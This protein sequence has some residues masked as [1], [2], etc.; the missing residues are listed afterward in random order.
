MCDDPGCV[1]EILSFCRRAVINVKEEENATPGEIVDD[2]SPSGDGII[3]NKI[4]KSKVVLRLSNILEVHLYNHYDYAYMYIYII[5]IVGTTYTSSIES[6]A[7]TENMHYT[8][9]IT[10]TSISDDAQYSYYNY[11][12][13]QVEGKKFFTL[14]HIA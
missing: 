3:R 8:K 6:T 11:E 10:G 9:E 13:S 1:D 5:L 7:S 4:W 12:V 2:S 14:L